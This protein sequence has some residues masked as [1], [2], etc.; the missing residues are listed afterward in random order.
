M[1][2]YVK[3]R[4]SAICNIVSEVLLV[5]R[6]AW[7]TLQQLLTQKRFQRIEDKGSYVSMEG[8]TV[9]IT[10]GSSG[11]GLATAKEL[12]R[13]KARVILACR[14]P[15]GSRDA[16]TRVFLET[17]HYVIVRRLDLT[18]FASVWEFAAD[19]LL[20]ES[21]LD[22]LIN[23]AAVIS[24]S[25]EVNITEDD[26]EHVMQ[27]NYMGHVLLTYFLLDLLKKS[28]PSRVINVSCGLHRLGSV[29]SIMRTIS[30]THRHFLHPGRVYY[31]SKLAQVLFTQVLAAELRD[32]GVT[33][34]TAD[35]GVV[36][37][38]ICV[39]YPGLQGA[40]IRYLKRQFG[41]TERQSAQTCAYLAIAPSVAQVTGK[42]YL[43]C[44]EHQPV[45][46][47]P[48]SALI[49]E[50]YDLTLRLSNAEEAERVLHAEVQ[51]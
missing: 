49:K 44:T 4:L 42:Y 15:D 18:S 13:R 33:V 46:D 37:T 7:I 43:D 40:L 30:D 25:Y 32:S 48:D 5:T 20:R 16:W 2:N 10:G 17:D 38:G 50:I 36:N 41:K 3:R 39:R 24:D 26:N 45:I 1:G 29:E 21:R 12:A 8:K 6:E 51:R 22:V 35:P 19:I 27:T 28:A 11:V 34:N 47:K 31:D 9:I 23:A 14:E